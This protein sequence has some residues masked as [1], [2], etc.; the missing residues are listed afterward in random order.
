MFRFHRATAAALGLM[1]LAL[2]LGGCA[3]RTVHAPGA[4]GEQDGG[5]AP[6]LVVERFLQA[7]NVVA[8]ST[9]GTVRQLDQVDAELQTMAR[10][11][12]TQRGPITSLYPRSEVEQRIVLLASILQHEDYRL[13]G[14]GLVP[15]RTGEAIRIMV[16]IRQ[17]E[18]N[19]TVPF[20]L[21]RSTSHGWLIEKFDAEKLTGG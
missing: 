15:G 2:A 12:G 3:T 18:T 4:S 5:V 10:L 9:G 13:E 20:T 17:G 7:A 11:F 14:E 1:V 6:A 21:V 8:Q 19:V 16:R